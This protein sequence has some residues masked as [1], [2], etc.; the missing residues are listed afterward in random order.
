VANNLL[1]RLAALGYTN[2]GNEVL[3]GPN[4]DFNVKYGALPPEMVAEIAEL[5]EQQFAAEVRRSPE[6]DSGSIRVFIN[7]PETK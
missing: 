6:I 7:I 5:V 4:G 3:S 1:K 2:A